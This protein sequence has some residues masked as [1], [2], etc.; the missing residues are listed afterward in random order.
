MDIRIPTHLRRSSGDDRRAWIAALPDLVTRF[1]RLWLLEVREPFE[2][3]GDT[4]W[5]AP[6]RGPAGEDLVLKLGWRHEEALHEAEGLR[7]WDGRGAV[8]L[9]AHAEA[10]ETQVLLLE[11]CVPGAELR[12]LAETDQD[13]VVTGLLRR[14]W[15]EPP[16]DH[17]LRPLGAMCDFWAERFEKDRAR[18]RGRNSLDSGLVDAG[19]DLLR[20][21]PHTADQSVVLC[22]DLH[23]GNILR[24][25]REPWLAIDPK[26][27]VGDPTYDALQHM[28]NCLDRLNADP[29]GLVG[30][31]A[32]LLDLDPARLRLWL[33]A[34]LVVESSWPSGRPEAASL[35]SRLAP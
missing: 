5:V 21:L 26:P 3:G 1:S 8:R 6:A 35:A 11:R 15:I 32:Y 34:R 10:P 9:Y 19:I 23:A 31:M 12:V 13:V 20:T 30:R 2:P 29:E 14:L 4:A 22:T 25:E 7:L 28:L 16:P 33:F 17:C 18:V 24:A 27:Y